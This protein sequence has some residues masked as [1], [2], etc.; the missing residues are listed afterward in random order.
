VAGEVKHSYTVPCASAFRDAALALA[1]RRRVN[2]GDL[3]RSVMLVLPPEEIL[4]FPDPGEPEAGD[5]ETVVLKSGPSEGRP[6]RRKPR[7]QVRMT[8]G[9][10][11]P[12]IRRALGIALAMEKGAVA[13]S[14]GGASAEALEAA[15]RSRTEL[16]GSMR[17]LRAELERERLAMRDEAANAREELDRLRAMVNVLMGDPLPQGVTSRQD[18]LF[19]LGFPPGTWPDGREVKSRFRML[20]TIHHPDSG[21]GS[22]DRMSQLNQAME[23]LRNR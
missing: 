21:M 1:D 14:M 15:E 19:V 13:V 16:E 5:R 12:F 3:A 2:V 4:A 8:K 11:V 7:L 18:A 9:H 20:A 6:W 22:H 23:Y 17:S 10:A